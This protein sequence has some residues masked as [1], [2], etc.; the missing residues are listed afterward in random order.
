MLLFFIFPN[1]LT[2]LL[3]DTTSDVITEE[4]Y[5]STENDR[6]SLKSKLADRKVTFCPVTAQA[7]SSV[8]AAPT[9][10]AALPVSAPGAPASRMS[11]VQTAQPGPSGSAA[12]TT[13]PAPAIEVPG[14]KEFDHTN[15]N[16]IKDNGTGEMG[17]GRRLRK[18][19]T[20][21]C[22]PTTQATGLLTVLALLSLAGGGCK[23]FRNL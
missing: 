14:S 4:I 10:P 18:A 3:K 23:G 16:Q 17:K 19:R 1:L 9:V 8:Q 12:S 22:C 13:K 11:T 2:S 20:C 21:K 6:E 15:Q 7:A 5:F